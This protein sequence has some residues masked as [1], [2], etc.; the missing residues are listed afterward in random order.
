MKCATLLYN[1]FISYNVIYVNIQSSST[2]PSMSLFDGT[3]HFTLLEFPLCNIIKH[4]IHFHCYADD[5]QLY[6]STKPD[7][8][9]QVVKLQAC[10]KDIKSGYLCS[11][12][13]SIFFYQ[14]KVK[15]I[16][17][18]YDAEKLVPAFV[19]FTLDKL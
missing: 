5:T 7:D 8:T 16:L 14:H 19:S 11:R 10:F 18:R 12:V 4:C 2:R 17:S 13:N 3:D 15:N 9:N 6:L 1:I